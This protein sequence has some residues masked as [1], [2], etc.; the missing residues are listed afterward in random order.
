MK[1]GWIRDIQ[2]ISSYSSPSDQWWRTQWPAPGA[3]R[4]SDCQIWNLF[5]IFDLFKEFWVNKDYFSQKMFYPILFSLYYRHIRTCNVQILLIY[6]EMICYDNFGSFI[7]ESHK[8]KT[9]FFHSWY[10]KNIVSFKS[11]DVKYVFSSW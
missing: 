3:W 4:R 7:K 2:F 6:I 10:K 5:I 9:L 8:K 1:S 11:I